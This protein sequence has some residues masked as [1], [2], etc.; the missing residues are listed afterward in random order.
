MPTVHRKDHSSALHVSSKLPRATGRIA[1]CFPMWM[2][3]SPLFSLRLLSDAGL[4]AFLR[5]GGPTGMF[6]E[7]STRPSTDLRGDVLEL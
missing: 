5:G 3:G 6:Q 1:S 2:D 4:R 7:P